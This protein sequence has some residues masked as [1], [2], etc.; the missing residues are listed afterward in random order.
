MIRLHVLAIFALLLTGCA[1]SQRGVESDPIA[2]LKRLDQERIL[3]AAG[4]A[5]VI[6][7]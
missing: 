2:L 1:S 7:I 3:L 5:A 6:H 4:D